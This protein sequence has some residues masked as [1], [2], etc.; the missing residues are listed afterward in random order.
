MVDA[1]AGAGLALTGDKSFL[2]APDGRAFLPSA[3]TGGSLIAKGDPVGVAFANLWQSGCPSRQDV[4]V[5]AD[6]ATS[7]IPHA[8]CLQ[9]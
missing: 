4:G 2:L 6:A 3:D 9:R 1:G 5:R 8:A 7:G